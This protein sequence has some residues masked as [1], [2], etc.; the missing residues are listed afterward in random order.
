MKLSDRAQLPS[1]SSLAAPLASK[2]DLVWTSI[3]YQNGPLE[4]DWLPKMANLLPAFTDL[5]ATLYCLVKSLSCSLCPTSIVFCFSTLYSTV[6][7]VSLM[8]SLKMSLWLGDTGIN[9]HL[10]L[11][12]IHPCT[13][14]E[15]D[16]MWHTWKKRVKRTISA[17][18]VAPDSCTKSGCRSGLEAPLTG[19]GG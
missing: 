5:I 16:T 10:V 15:E 3:G 17:K 1:L 6:P 14:R 13:Q 4:H 18:T 12:V 11:H 9:L 7:V 8:T 19:M 2:H